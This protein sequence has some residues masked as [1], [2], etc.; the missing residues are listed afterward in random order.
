MIKLR[1]IND[2]EAGRITNSVW[3]SGTFI[4]YVCMRLMY[5]GNLGTN[6]L[7]NL[8]SAENNTW[9]ILPSS[10]CFRFLYDYDSS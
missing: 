1:Y 7:E 6:I 10:L 9:S 3:F 4:I 2:Q 5:S 8:S